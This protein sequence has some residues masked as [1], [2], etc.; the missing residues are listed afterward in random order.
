MYN[1]ETDRYTSALYSLSP[2]MPREDWITIALAFS[3]AV[4]GDAG[5]IVFDQWSQAGS[6]YKPVDTKAVW[7]MS[8]VNYPGRFGVN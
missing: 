4:P 8:G 3:D 5:F 6:T 7:K 1:D 2:D